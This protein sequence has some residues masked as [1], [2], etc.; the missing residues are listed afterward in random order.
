MMPEQVRG[1]DNAGP[2]AAPCWARSGC[3]SSSASRS[4]CSSGVFFPQHGGRA[5]AAWR[6]IHQAHPHDARAHHLRQ[7]RHRHRP[8]G[9][10]QRSGPRRRQ[11]THLLRSRLHDCAV[12]GL[13]R[14]E[15]APSRPRNEHRCRHTRCHAIS[16]YT[17]Q[18][19]HWSFVALPAQHHSF[20]H[21]R[22]VRQRQYSADHSLQRAVWTGALAISRGRA[23]ACRIC[24]IS[25]SGH[26]RHRQLHHASCAHW[27][28]RRHGLHHR[29][30][31]RAQPHAARP[32]HRRTLDRVH[33]L[34][35][36]GARAHRARQPGS[37]CS[38]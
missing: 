5:Q 3:R 19:Q 35:R 22:A 9:R 32:I 34:R 38:S 27:S 2:L 14:R 13:D 24:S 20:Q 37:A 26:V 1:A 6:W 29:P 18:R 15:R 33:C 12:H 30:V 8:H 4:A 16:S 7:R 11:S 36:C 31:W 17:A 23:P 25:C 21:R 10:P 28:L